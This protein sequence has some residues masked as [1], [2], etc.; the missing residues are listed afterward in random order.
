[1]ILTARGPR[2]AVAGR[3]QH[4]RVHQ[5]RAGARRRRASRHSGFGCLTGQGNGQGGREHGQKADQLPGYR[6]IDDDEA[7]AHMADMWGVPASAIPGAGKS[8]YE[9]LIVD[10]PRRRRARAAGHGIEHRRLGAERVRWCASGCRRSEF[11]VVADFFLSETAELADVVLPCTQWAEEEGTMTNLEGRVAAAA[12]GARSRRPA[13]APTSRSSARSA[14][15][16]AIAVSSRARTARRCSTSCAARVTAARADYFGITYERVE[17]EQG[18]FWPCPS[19]GHPGTERLFADSFPTPNSRA[20]FHAVSHRSIGEETNEDARSTSRPA[21][22]S[23]STSQE[24]RPGASARS[25]TPRSRSSRCTRPRAR[26]VGVAAGD[27]VVL[28]TRRGSATFVVKTTP[29]IR[30]DTVFAPFHWAGEQSANRL[31]NAAL[32]PT[33]KMPEF[34]VCATRIERATQIRAGLRQA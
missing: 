16:S 34:K 31:T 28:T 7:R 11:L 19:I 8:A 10:R 3:Q 12:E 5:P 25:G 29:S 4:A 2:A 18:V 33:S 30:E 22:F 24:R 1:M 32:D 14:S 23:G 27:R 26:V 6:R 13:S 9:L 15:A 20:R 17:N 21:A